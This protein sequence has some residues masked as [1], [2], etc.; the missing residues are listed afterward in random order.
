MV[1]QRRPNSAMPLLMNLSSSRVNRLGVI[2]TSSF[3]WEAELN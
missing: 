3:P 2:F 1:D